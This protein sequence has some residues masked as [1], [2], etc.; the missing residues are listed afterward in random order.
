MVLPVKGNL[1][2]I[3]AIVAFLASIFLAAGPLS[4]AKAAY[5]EPIMPYLVAAKYPGQLE[6]RKLSSDNGF[7]Y[8]ESS[9]VKGKG[10]VS[11]RGS[12]SDHALDSSGWM[13]GSGSIN[14]ETLRSMNKINR[15]VNFTQKSDLVFEGGQLKNIRSLEAPLFDRRIGASVTERFNLSHVDK[16]EIDMI[17]S[18]NSFDN[19]LV[20]N[21]EMAYQG[22]WD[23]KNQQGSLFHIKKSEQQY[24]GSFQAKKDI[25]FHDLGKT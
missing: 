4:I 12:F 5:G 2:A 22:T 21:A 23:I 18:N 16:S 7:H 24:S 20:Y 6:A 3:I 9:V 11:L 1:V 15:R 17:R 13:K 8:N 14:F 10:N 25:E 19:S